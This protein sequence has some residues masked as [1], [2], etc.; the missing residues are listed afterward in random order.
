M[1][2]R[3]ASITL[4]LFLVCSLFPGPVSASSYKMGKNRACL[5]NAFSNWTAI[6]WY[7][8]GGL[9]IAQ[10]LDYNS[11]CIQMDY[12]MK[13]GAYGRGENQKVQMTVAKWDP[14]TFTWT[15][16]KSTV[17]KSRGSDFWGTYNVEDVLS[18]KESNG[19][20]T[21]MWDSTKP[22]AR[23]RVTAFASSGG[24]VSEAK[25]EFWFARRPA[26]TSNGYQAAPRWIATRL[27]R[28]DYYHSAASAWQGIKDTPTSSSTQAGLNVV[29]DYSKGFVVGST[30][31]LISDYGLAT[32][33][34]LNIVHY[35]SQILGHVLDVMGPVYQCLSYVQTARDLLGSGINNAIVSATYADITK[36]AAARA[37]DVKGQL[38]TLAAALQGEAI[39]LQNHVYSNGTKENW[40]AW[41]QYE[42]AC[43]TKAITTVGQSTASIESYC[44]NQVSYYQS[45][46][47][48]NSGLIQSHNT[49]K[50]NLTKYLNS[51]HRQLLFD[52][53][54]IAEQIRAANQTPNPNAIR[55][56]N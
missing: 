14:A 16:I 36:L 33:E 4:V 42:Y 6:D 55:P 47:F 54:I 19:A 22:V 24:S 2:R 43:L 46:P 25:R 5:D 29:L 13:D 49:V 45:F 40:I 52:Q 20:L 15:N 38:D 8:P 18:V 28:S 3:I 30:P 48:V 35:N 44:N 12:Q 41:L 27:Q 9:K 10:I 31:E 37:G 34:V 23:Y 11:L 53:T 26:N 1:K 50:T 39:A 17:T 51:I 21:N 7:Y 56:A 32:M